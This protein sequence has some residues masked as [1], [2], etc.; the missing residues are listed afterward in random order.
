MINTKKADVSQVF[1]YLFSIII[2]TFA[3]FLVVKFIG[4]FSSDVDSRTN[5]VFFDNLEATYNQVAKNWNSEKLQTLKLTNDVEYVCFVESTCNPS[6]LSPPLSSTTSISEII[7][8]GDNILLFSSPENLIQTGKIGP[9]QVENDCTC[10]ETQQNRI[11]IFV[12][13]ERNQVSIS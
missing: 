10:M 9:F 1:V 11:E 8:G 12:V 7:E 13:N 4:V 2:I 5:I 6:T 3:G